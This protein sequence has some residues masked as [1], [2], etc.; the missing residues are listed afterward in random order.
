[1]PVEKVVPIL[2]G[3]A[4]SVTPVF[5][6]SSFI[7]RYDQCMPSKE[8]KDSMIQ[9]VDFKVVPKYR[10][11]FAAVTAG[12]FTYQNFCDYYRKKASENGASVPG[13]KGM[14]AAFLQLSVRYY[15]EAHDKF[16]TD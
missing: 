15:D 14:D 1:M 11:G 13:R 6:T 3:C 16:I 8:I 7:D 12:E 5:D 2:P 4:A 9:T 10:K